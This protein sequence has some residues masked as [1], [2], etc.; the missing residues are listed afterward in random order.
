MS[1]YY[2]AI[3]RYYRHVTFAQINHVADG[4]QTRYFTALGGRPD[5][6]PTALLGSLRAIHRT[7]PNFRSIVLPARGHCV[8]PTPAYDDQTVDG[9]RLRSWVADLVAGRP[10]RDLG[11]R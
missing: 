6:F 2:A 10:V 3:A 5:D 8:L 1:D 11:G 9:V 7:A 4:V